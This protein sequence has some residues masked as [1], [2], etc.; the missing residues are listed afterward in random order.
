MS[1]EASFKWNQAVL[2]RIKHKTMEALVDLGEDTA[3]EAQRHAPVGVYPAESGRTGGALVN[4]IRTTKTD[5]QVIILAGGKA[6]GK[7][8]PYARI[9]EYVNY[10]NPH[11]RFY[12]RNALEWANN[13]I[14]KYFKDIT[15]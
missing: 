11:T 8:I 4:S 3:Y 1:S 6:D 10:K 13:N 9:R 14:S 7:Y 2:D 15:K 12:M 5:N